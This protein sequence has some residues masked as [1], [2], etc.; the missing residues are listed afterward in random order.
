MQ[1]GDIVLKAVL[2][3]IFIGSLFSLI[4][5]FGLFMG[6]GWAARLNVSMR[7][8]VSTREMLRPLEVPRDIN[9]H[10]LRWH[11]GA[12]FFLILAGAYVLYTVALRFDPG[13]IALL[14]QKRFPDWLV[15]IVA[16]TLRWFIA[17]GSA[18]GLVIGIVLVFRPDLVRG[19]EAWAARSYSE[20]RA[21]KS[22]DEMKFGPDQLILSAPRVS[23]ALIIIASLYV[24]LALG[25]LLITKL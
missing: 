17:I 3:F 18:A 16:E 4:F 2:I 22:L 13:A 11:R 6:Q 25:D 23:G 7:R 19:I 14:Y 21:T 15:E 20:R 24:A 5:G 9:P 10:I 8:W 1:L 12:G